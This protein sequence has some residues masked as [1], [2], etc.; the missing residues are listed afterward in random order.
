MY[1]SP[2]FTLEVTSD[3]DRVFVGGEK[4]SSK[5][6]LSQGTITNVTIPGPGP[7][8]FRL[9][10]GRDFGLPLHISKVSMGELD[11]NLQLLLGYLISIGSSLKLYFSVHILYNLRLA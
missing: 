9:A 4:E 8:G 3:T 11:S 7:F 6:S 10:G 1:K 5:M 2:T